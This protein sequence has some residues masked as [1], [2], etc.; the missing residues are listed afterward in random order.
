MIWFIY[1]AAF[2]DEGARALYPEDDVYSSRKI[3]HFLGLG[4]E[5]WFGST[6]YGEAP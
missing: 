5:W 6:S 4:A 2:R 3:E 1:S